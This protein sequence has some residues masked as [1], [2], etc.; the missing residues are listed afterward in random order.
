[1][2][3]TFKDWQQPA[4]EPTWQDVAKLYASGF[5]GCTLDP[6]KRAAERERFHAEMPHA[7]GEEVCHGFGFADSAAGKLVPTWVAVEQ[8]YP[9]CWP[10]SAQKRGDCVSHSQ[11]NAEL[12]T[13]VGEVVA[14]LPD[15]VSGKT[16][17]APQVSPE[18]QRDGVLATEAKYRHRGSRGDGWFCL[19]AARVAVQT[20]GAVLRKDYPGIANLTRYNPSWAGGSAGASERD[21]FDDNKFREATEPTTFEAIRD[22]L[23]RGFGVSS[24]GSEGF[25][26][27]RDDW[28]VSR[29]QGSWAHAMAI[30]GA[31]DRAD[32]KA[33]Y[34][35]PLLLVL[36]SWGPAWNS[37]PTRVNGTTLDIPKGSFWAKW[38]DLSRRSFCAMA[39]LHGWERRELPDYLGGWQ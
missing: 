3:T 39:G 26:N 6:V 18:A 17:E 13:L 8:T 2:P 36:N 16:E 35:G 1:V 7:N 34:G 11:R 5:S 23:S 27:T 25:S 32:T 28:G 12:T 21:A 9:G 33:K 37:G 10:A 4:V 24:C 29:R 22:L 31:D 30:I 19:A 15:A 38:S 14:G 20:T